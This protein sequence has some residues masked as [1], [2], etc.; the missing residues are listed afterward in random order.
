[1]EGEKTEG[2][3]KSAPPFFVYSIQDGLTGTAAGRGVLDVEEGL[4]VLR[5]GCGGR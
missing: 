4:G 2:Q 1:M 5:H 3:V